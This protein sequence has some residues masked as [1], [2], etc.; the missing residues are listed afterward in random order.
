MFGSAILDVALGLAFVYLLLSVLCSTVREA[1]EGVLNARGA[2]LERGIREL[3]GGAKDGQ[4]LATALYDHPLVAGLYRGNYSDVKRNKAGDAKAASNLPSYIPG[5]NVALA[6]LDLAARGPAID[7]ASAT[8]SEQVVLTLQS[9]RDNIGNIE[10]ASVRR[11]LLCAID[12]ADDD[13]HRAVK[14]VSD[15]YDS[16]MERVSGWYRRESQAILFALGLIVAIVANVN[17]VTIA[18]ALYHD[19]PLRDA[20]V[21]E[22]GRVAADQ[23]ATSMTP[24]QINEE[25]HKTGLPIGAASGR[26]SAPPSSPPDWWPRAFAPI[27]PLVAGLSWL[28]GYLATAAAVSFGAPFWFDL[29]NR[30]VAMRGSSKP[31]AKASETAAAP[32]DGVAPTSP[33]RVAPVGTAGG[34]AVGTA[35]GTASAASAAARFTPRAWASG[36]ADEGLL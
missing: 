22:A 33:A 3:L 9:A 36:S 32:A 26:E 11:A 17:S 35:G 10:N 20:L 25:L 29:L 27:W 8:G 30:F 13:F 14:N 31:G 5:K 21:A 16:A 23:G 24:R 4:A 7:G 2:K 18:S 28:V 34:T 15:W 12:S 1:I 19:K 6:L